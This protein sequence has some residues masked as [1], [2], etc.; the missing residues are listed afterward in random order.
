MKKNIIFLLQE[1]NSIDQITPLIVFLYK[2]KFNVIL[3]KCT[4]NYNYEDDNNLIYIK[5]NCK[6]IIIKD[7]FLDTNKIYMYLHQFYN[8]INKKYSIQK[9]YI[10]KKVCY[11]LRGIVR[12]SLVNTTL[13]NEYYLD[14]LYNGYNKYDTI[15]V[16]EITSGDYNYEACVIKAY[17]LGITNISFTHGFDVLTNNLL[18]FHEL[19]KND[20]TISNHAT[21]YSYK[22]I[23]FNS[24]AKKRM[25][26][27]HF[28]KILQFPSLR[29]STKWVNQIGGRTAKVK[30]QNEINCRLKIV[31]M[32]SAVGY[33]IWIEEQFRTIQMVLLQKDIYL[34]IKV[35]PRDISVKNMFSKINNIN[36]EVVDNHITSSSLIDWADI[37]MTIGSGIIIESI[38]K[39]KITFY[40]KYLHCN[41]IELENTK[42]IIHQIETR[43]ELL[44]LI[45]KYKN[46]T[47]YK[48]I[49]LKERQELLKDYIGND[50]FEENCEMYLK[51]FKGL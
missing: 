30:F 42:K 34:V 2:S 49:D 44:S 22:M 9:L 33:N 25:G 24:L 43:D 31:F 28:S 6:D 27:M 45:D 37:V 18:S 19:E 13:I 16:T 38:I 12:R 36:F 26:E 40:M 21:N 15:L 1:H 46:N 23:V 50:N 8:F 4:H 39:N 3:I 32:L 11:L 5:M 51:L 35:H 41:K 14:K 17:N 20:I 47:D 7:L 29:F 48:Y 10:L